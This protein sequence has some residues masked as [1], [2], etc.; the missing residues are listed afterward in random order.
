[1]E[2]CKKRASVFGGYTES[3]PAEG[4]GGFRTYAGAIKGGV[5]A[6]FVWFIQT[7]KSK[8]VGNNEKNRL[9]LLKVGESAAGFLFE[10]WYPEKHD[11]ERK[12]GDPHV[13]MV[14]ES[15]QHPVS[16]AEPDAPRI[17]ERGRQV[18]AF[19]RR[20]RSGAEKGARR[21]SRPFEQTHRS[22]IK[23][24]P[25]RPGICFPWSWWAF[26]CFPSFARE[27][28]YPF[29]AP[30]RTVTGSKKSEGPFDRECRLLVPSDCSRYK[31][32]QGQ[33]RRGLPQTSRSLPFQGRS[34]QRQC[35]D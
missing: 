4:S 22:F 25:T 21:L 14:S 11:P 23:S 6:D 15:C 2:T 35:T 29:R 18:N 24:T 34:H 7:H 30:A 8:T 13:Q 32:P 1:L 5:R 16:G 3:R 9:L 27:S 28:Q 10:T 19:E 20:G 31:N 26:T 33:S 12:G 17:A